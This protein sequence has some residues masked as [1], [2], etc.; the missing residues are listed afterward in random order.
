V[1]KRYRE[2]ALEEVEK[3]LRIDPPHLQAFYRWA[4]IVR[5]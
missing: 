5:L 4:E 1:K 3:V 2:E